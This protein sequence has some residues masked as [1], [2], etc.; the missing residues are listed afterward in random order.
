MH[1]GDTEPNS[2]YYLDNY[3]NISYSNQPH[4]IYILWLQPYP[5]SWVIYS[6]LEP[7]IN[8]PNFLNPNNVLNTLIPPKQ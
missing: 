7:I 8:I 3:F 2:K 6:F 4:S 5:D 1:I